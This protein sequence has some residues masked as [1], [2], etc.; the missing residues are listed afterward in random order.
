MPDDN[1]RS[2]LD[3]IVRLG[4]GEG[5]DTHF[6]LIFREYY[7]RV[8]GFLARKLNS[9]QDVEDLT[10][11]TFCK[12]YKDGRA[13]RDSNEFEAWLFGIAVFVHRSSHKMQNAKKRRPPEIQVDLTENVAEPAASENGPL[14][15]LLGREL[16][17]IVDQALAE[18]PDKMRRCA[19]LRYRHDRSPEEI[20]RLV[21]LSSGTVR[22]HLYQ[23][24]LRLKALLQPYVE[25]PEE[26]P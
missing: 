8:R 12:V 17:E 16:R 1:R 19:I 10:Q 3:E 22:A 14:G 26:E 25:I 11:E 23:A 20:A 6:H 4:T 7:P 13:F 21:G 24:R 2:V 5:R 15:K 9:P 18:L